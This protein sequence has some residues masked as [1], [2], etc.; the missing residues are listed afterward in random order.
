[1]VPSVDASLGNHRIHNCLHSG[2]IYCLGLKTGADLV[3]TSSFASF[4]PL[5]IPIFV[6]FVLLLVALILCRALCWDVSSGVA[7]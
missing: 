7:S 5:L 2:D 4:V 6:H 3:L 1:M